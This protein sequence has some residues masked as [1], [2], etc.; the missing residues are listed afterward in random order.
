MP[1]VVRPRRAGSPCLP[2]I[3]QGIKQAGEGREAGCWEEQSVDRSRRCMAPLLCCACVATCRDTC[4]ACCTSCCDPARWVHTHLR[5]GGHTNQVPLAVTRRLQGARSKGG[6][7]GGR[8]VAG[9]GRLCNLAREGTPLPALPASQ[10]PQQRFHANRD[11]ALPAHHIGGGLA[12]ALW[13]GHAACVREE[14]GT[15]G[16]G[17]VCLA[18]HSAPAPSHPTVQHHKLPAAPRLPWRGTCLSALRKHPPLESRNKGR[19][20][21]VRTSWESRTMARTCTRCI[22][23]IG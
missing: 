21:L 20:P 9:G 7:T 22:V 18:T 13:V 1:P 16:H 23:R 14:T 10:M 11:E 15:G 5:Q 2:G 4:W 19:L 6:Q 3:K 8:E 17:R 12:G